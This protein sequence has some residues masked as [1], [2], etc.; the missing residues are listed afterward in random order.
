[1][2]ETAEEMYYDG[3]YNLFNA[4]IYFCKK[5]TFT[6]KEIQMLIY[7]IDGCLSLYEKILEDPEWSLPND[8]KEFL[9]K[10]K[11]RFENILNYFDIEI[12]D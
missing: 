9:E 3:Y 11:E 1:M 10:S 7:M 12:K 6:V 8:N 5:T 2:E 4:C